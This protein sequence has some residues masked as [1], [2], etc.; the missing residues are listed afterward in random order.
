M[1]EVE[2]EEDLPLIQ[3]KVQLIMEGQLVLVV[4]VLAFPQVLEDHKVLLVMMEIHHQT[5]LVKLVKMALL[6]RVVI[7]DPIHHLI[8][9]KL[10]VVLVLVQIMVVTLLVV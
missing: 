4:A 3:A 5:M 7:Q 9:I 6:M 2:E 8:M 1:V 10:Q